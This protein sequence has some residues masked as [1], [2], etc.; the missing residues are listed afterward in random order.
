M[1]SANASVYD[2][3]SATA[4]AAAMCRD[5]KRMRT[6]ISA[7]CHPD[8][9]ATVKTYCW[10]ADCEIQVIPEKDGATDLE[11]LSGLLGED[12]A[13]V[14]LSQPNYFGVLED[15]EAAAQAAHAAGAKF[16]LNVNPIA[17]VSYTHLD[18]AHHCNSVCVRAFPPWPC[19][20]R[21]P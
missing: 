11:A 9:I 10:A 5:R 12:S 13:C 4:E 3:A 2:G 14:I 21:D 6:L 17:A 1:D 15:A 18:G 16:V 8:V 20:H 19:D 7:A